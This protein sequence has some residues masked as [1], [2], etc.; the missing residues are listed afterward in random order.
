MPC[1][2]A[3]GRCGKTSPVV[4]VRGRKVSIYR[5]DKCAVDNLRQFIKSLILSC[6]IQKCEFCAQIEYGLS[7]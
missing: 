2:R 3:G 7:I 6:N 5:G 4:R 1:C